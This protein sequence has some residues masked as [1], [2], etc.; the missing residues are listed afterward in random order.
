MP[1]SAL[2]RLAAPCS[3]LQHSAD[4]ERLKVKRFKQSLMSIFPDA[5]DLHQK[6]KTLFWRRI[7][8]QQNNPQQGSCGM[9][10]MKTLMVAS[11]AIFGS[12]CVSMDDEG[13]LQGDEQIEEVSA[14]IIN[15]S[16]VLRNQGTGI[17]MDGFVSQGSAPYQFSCNSGNA[18]QRWRLINT[19]TSSGIVVGNLRNDGNGLCLDGFGNTPYLW[20]CNSG[21]AYQRWF[22]VGT[23]LINQQTQKCL[24]GF[25]SGSPYQFTCSGS[26]AFHRWNNS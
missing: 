26:N 12:A 11:V 7:A 1:C 24:D 25:G 8:N 16:T 15:S 3:A 22:R 18:F 19:A 10:Q 21:N 17:C 5:I 20:P 14:E 6:F 13:S 2:Q 9:S 4:L 23:Q